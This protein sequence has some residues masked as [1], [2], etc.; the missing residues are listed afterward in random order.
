L[1]A[2]GL[3]YLALAVLWAAPSSLSP[4]TVIPDVGDP[5]HLSWVMSWDAHQL[6]RRPW[7]LFEA[8]TFYP[9]HR[10]LAFGDHLLPEALM[11][12]PVFYATGNA[13]LASNV[14]VLL[15]LALSGLAM[16]LLVSEVLEAPGAAF[17]AGLAYA[18]NSFTRSEILR[19]QVLNIEWWPLAFLFLVRF[20]RDGRARD[21]CALVLFLLFEGLSGAYYLIYSA[22]LAPFWIAIAYL[23]FARRP[24]GR[25]VRILAVAALGAALVALPILLQYAIQLRSMGFEK[26]LREG[27]DVLSYVNPAASSF[28]GRLRVLPAE[29]GVPHFLGLFGVLLIA[30]GAAAVLRPGVPPERRSLGLVALATCACGF[31]LSLGPDVVLGGHRLGPGPYALLYRFV[32]LARGMSS[33]N[34]AAVLVLLGGAVLLGFGAAWARSVL[35]RALGSAALLVLGLLLPLEQWSPPTTGMRVPTGRDVPEAYRFLAAGD[36]SPMIDLPLYPDVAKRYWALY[37]YF[38]TY[39]WRPIPI[40]RTSFYP[41]AHDY[42][43]WSLRGFPDDLSLGILEHLGIR[44]LV[45]HP[46]VWEDLGER[47]RKLAI[48]DSDPRLRLVKAFEDVPPGVPGLQLGRER[49]YALVGGGTPPSPL[50]TPSEELPRGSW[51]LSGTGVTSPKRA[52]DGDRKT[53]WSTAAPQ[54]PGDRLEVRFPAPEDVSALTIDLWYP[55]AEF[56]RNLVVF[57]QGEEGGLERVPYEDGPDVRNATIDALVSRPREATMVLRLKPARARAFRLMVGLRERDPAWAAFSVPEV[58]AYRECR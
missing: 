53:A 57:L 42:L 26:P 8:N 12:A 51:T 32:P 9:Y 4:A 6:V 15:A 19:V 39:H 56:P 58:H 23:V 28:L 1:A 36:G 11:A 50:C 21:G 55:H 10:S 25:E 43:A 20:V 2:A 24:R 14:A 3:A 35:P 16:F 48:L 29:A 45:V 34:R 38:S 37:L 41:P 33:P 47:A 54:K 17:L 30:C 31:L 44:T 52:V 22:L 13:V 5:L 46:F 49:I 40:G 27:V 7:A 18:F